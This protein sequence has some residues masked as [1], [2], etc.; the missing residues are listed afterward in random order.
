MGKF[1]AILFLL[2]LAVAPVHAGFL[3]NCDGPKARADNHLAL[4][5]NIYWEASNQSVDGQLAVAFVTMNRVLST[6]YP[7]T[8]AEVVWQHKLGKRTR[9]EIAQFSWTKDGKPDTVHSKRGWEKA[10]K[11]AALFTVSREQI[12]DHC[13]NVKLQWVI[14]DYVDRPRRPLVACPQAK[15]LQQLRLITMQYHGEDVTNGALFYH[16]NYVNPWWSKP[17]YKLIKTA[18][19]G[20]HIFYTPRRRSTTRYD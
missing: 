17:K 6:H 2:L 19:I 15:I 11:I 10:L 14:D 5:C 8:F 13:P 12:I 9:R 4:A 20:D 16:A 1:R 7:N 3:E 18:V